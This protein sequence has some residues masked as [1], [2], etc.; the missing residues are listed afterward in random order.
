MPNE[1]NKIIK[2]NHGEKSMKHPGVI[3]SDLESI[4]KKMHLCQRNSKK[5]Y[6]EKK[7]CIYPLVICCLHNVHLIQQKINLTVIELKTAWKSFVK[8]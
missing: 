2:Y 3:Y 7:I 6:T 4:L 1:D 5:S 8:V